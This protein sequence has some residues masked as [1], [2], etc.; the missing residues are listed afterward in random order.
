MFGVLVNVYPNY[1]AYER[2]EAVFWPNADGG[3][4]DGWNIIKVVKHRLA[5]KLHGLARVHTQ[6]NFGYGLELLDGQ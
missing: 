2:F 1:A 4:E 5:N 3:P 6:W